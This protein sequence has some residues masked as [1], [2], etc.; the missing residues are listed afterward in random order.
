M[1]YRYDVK[2]RLNGNVANEVM[3][4]NVSAAEVMILRALHEDDAVHVL[5]E[6]TGTGEFI[7]ERDM[8]RL[9]YQKTDDPNFNR[10]KID[11]DRMFGPDHIDLP[12]RLK[13]FEK[14]ER[15]LREGKTIDPKRRPG[16][17]VDVPDR[18]VMNV[19][20]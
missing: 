2:V 12:S 13:D 10:T 4:T 18:E 16:S 8:L 3:R 19:V 5:R 1:F 11:F 15:E 9:R 20:A 14:Q 6:F 17:R 7:E